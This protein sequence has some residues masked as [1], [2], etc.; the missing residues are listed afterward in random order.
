MGQFQLVGTASN[1]QEIADVMN[2]RRVQ[3]G[4]TMSEMNDI[5]GFA[6][7]YVNKIFASGYPKQLGSISLPVFL[8]TLGLR[9]CLVADDHALPPVTRRAISE[10]VL[11]A[12]KTKMPK[13]SAEKGS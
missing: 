5:T 6:D 9:L 8:E 11:S 4:L 2:M 13:K 1:V 7:R 3:L 12:S 10:K